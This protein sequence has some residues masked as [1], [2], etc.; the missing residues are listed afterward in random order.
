MAFADAQAR[1]DRQ[2]KREMDLLQCRALPSAYTFG[3][4]E[5]AEIDELYEMSVGAID[6]QLASRETF[7]RVLSQRPDLTFVLRHREEGGIRAFFAYILLSRAGQA[8]AEQDRFIGIDPAPHHLTKS[9][10]PGVALY[11]WVSV[12]QRLS[13]VALPRAM[14]AL[15]EPQYAH[16]DIYSR[17]GTPGGERAM[18]N[19]GFRAVIP[20]ETG[21]IGEITVYRRLANILREE[22]A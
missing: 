2:S 7:H 17:P 14:R 15:Q 9:V 13:L 10:S 4:L 21:A 8:A 5:V 1:S 18:R 6:S 19:L 11:S 16:L 20:G 22:A 12:A 3:T